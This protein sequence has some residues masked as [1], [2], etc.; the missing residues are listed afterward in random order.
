MIKLDNNLEEG[1]KIVSNLN[2]SIKGEICGIGMNEM[3][4]IGS[5]YIIK[6]TKRIGENWKNY[7]YSCICLPQNSFTI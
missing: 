5:I 3:P 6:I 4:V 2:G 7:P 1:T